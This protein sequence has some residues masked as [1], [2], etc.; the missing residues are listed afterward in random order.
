MSREIRVFCAWLSIILSCFLLVVGVQN[1][2]V[3][4]SVLSMIM[5][6]AFLTLYTTIVY[7][8]SMKQFSE[9][10][11]EKE[12]RNPMKLEDLLDILQQEI[13]KYIDEDKGY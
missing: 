12:R 13:D 8:I 1:T 7:D 6:F 3:I 9:E 11:L 10:L 2:S 5:F 4:L